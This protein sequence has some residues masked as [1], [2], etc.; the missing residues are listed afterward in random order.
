MTAV[1]SLAAGHYLHWGV[2]SISL[3]N[4]LVIVT[5]IVVFVLAILVPFPH[6]SEA[7]D[8]DEVPGP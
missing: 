7:P 3:T 2:V 5:M 6:R 1:L 8:V 4:A